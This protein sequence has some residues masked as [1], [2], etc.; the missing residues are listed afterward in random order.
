MRRQTTKL[1]SRTYARSPNVGLSAHM[2]EAEDEYED[3]DDDEGLNPTEAARRAVQRPRRD[4]AAEVS[5]SLPAVLTTRHM[6]VHRASTI[7]SPM[8]TC[9][10]LHLPVHPDIQMPCTDALAN[11]SGSPLTIR[12]Y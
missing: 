11:S 5:A 6:T 8:W 9:L 1:P 2:L 10:P 12:P 3:E 4:E 7:C